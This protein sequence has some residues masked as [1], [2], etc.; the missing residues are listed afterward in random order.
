MTND[1]PFILVGQ[2][3]QEV[4]QQLSKIDITSLATKEQQIVERLRNEIVD[5]R[6]EV[7]DYELAETRDDQLRNAQ[8][9]KKRLHKAEQLILLNPGNVFGPV[10]VA[11]I[12]AYISDI[13]DK[14]R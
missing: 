10:D 8:A 13:R 3:K 9:A 7:K 5:A 11:H 1:S 2:L 4:L 6:L 14:L 12:S